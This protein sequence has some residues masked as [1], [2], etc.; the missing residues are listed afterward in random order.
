MR[1]SEMSSSRNLSQ[2][3]FAMRAKIAGVTLAMLLLTLLSSST[4][5][6]AQ[7]LSGTLRVEVSDS[8]GALVPDAKVTV[9]NDATGVT[10]TISGGPAG[11]YTFP[12]LNV[13]TYTVSVE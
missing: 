10:S 13:G 7:T 3:K 2:L 8:T 6:W 1:R 11:L 5:T 4:F 12:S 9:T